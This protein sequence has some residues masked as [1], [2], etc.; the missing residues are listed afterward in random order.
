MELLVSVCV[1]TLFIGLSRVSSNITLER[2]QDMSDN[3]A[4]NFQLVHVIAGLRIQEIYEE[5]GPVDDMSFIIHNLPLHLK[6]WPHGMKDGP[7]G[8]SS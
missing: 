7:E 3:Y 6:G 1:S 5:Y 4:Q 8:C 2:N